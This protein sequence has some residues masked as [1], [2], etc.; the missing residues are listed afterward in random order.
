MNQNLLKCVEFCLKFDQNETI[1]E[2]ERHFK[3]KFAYCFVQKLF[4]I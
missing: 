2:A 1:K 3:S 4:G